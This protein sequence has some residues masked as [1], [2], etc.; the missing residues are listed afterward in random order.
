MN[1]SHTDLKVA[2]S[3]GQ[4]VLYEE[5][6]RTE[7]RTNKWESSVADPVLFLPLDPE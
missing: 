4:Q 1:N 2:D 3:S 6:K 5:M 7:K